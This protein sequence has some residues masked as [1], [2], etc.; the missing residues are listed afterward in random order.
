MGLLGEALLQV[1]PQQ[2]GIFKLRPPLQQLILF[3][4]F[5]R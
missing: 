1:R 3:I 5:L 4:E 2:L